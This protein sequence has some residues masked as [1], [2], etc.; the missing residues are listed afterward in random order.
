MAD[1]NLDGERKYNLRNDR[2]FKESLRRR[3]QKQI[4]LN[5]LEK[6]EKRNAPA[7]R[8][9]FLLAAVGQSE[10]LAPLYTLLCQTYSCACKWEIVVAFGMMIH[11]LF[12][13]IR[14]P[15]SHCRTRLFPIESA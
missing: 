7:P 15:Y 6:K 11:Q 13:S 8:A 12:D 10:N 3:T 14:F 1:F 2:R 9:K 5:H 4:C